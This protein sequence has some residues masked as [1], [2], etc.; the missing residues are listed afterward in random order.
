VKKLIKT[1]AYFGGSFDP[2]HKG[3]EAMI[4]AVCSAYTLD[5]LVLIPTFLSP[6]KSQSYFSSV[7][8]LKILNRAAFELEARFNVIIEISNYETSLNRSNYTIDTLSTLCNSDHKNLFL[9]GSDSL[10]SFH[11]W[12]RFSSILKIVDLIVVR[13]DFEYYDSYINTYL[14]QD[15]DC[16]H[17]LSNIPVEISSTEV[18]NRLLN[19]QDISDL[20]PDYIDLIN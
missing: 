1:V 17:V 4:S 19:Q 13:R 9:I 18:R 16:V 8:R 7:H 12:E 6:H 3:H 11:T 2:F 20:I 5:K 10:C 14:K 15:R